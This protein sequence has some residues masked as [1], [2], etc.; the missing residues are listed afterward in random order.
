MAILTVSNM[1]FVPFISIV[2]PN[3]SSWPKLLPQFALHVLDFDPPLLSTYVAT[4]DEFWSSRN[5]QLA[6]VTNFLSTTSSEWQR[7]KKLGTGTMS[8]S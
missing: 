7:R 4:P 2:L 8:I 5:E 6:E 3:I 1:R